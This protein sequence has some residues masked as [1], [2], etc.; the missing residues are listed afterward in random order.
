MIQVVL[1]RPG[2]TAY[3]EQSRV[4]GILDLPLSDRGRQEVQAL[5]EHLDTVELTAIY[6]GPG[7]NVQSTADALGK[8]MG[9]R[10]RRLEEL[11]NIDQGLWQ[12]L[13]VDEIKRRS[14]KVYRLW[15]EEPRTICPPQGEAVDDAQDRV[16]QALKPILKRH[17]DDRIAIVVA[18]P[19]ARLVAGFLRRE[20]NP[21]FLEE[22][23]TGCFEVIEV[24]P[25]VWKNGD[26]HGH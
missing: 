14:P 23:P 4:Q 9:L 24:P 25:D 19:L 5:A 17:R 2:A 6:N 26:S 16:R 11:R 1:I 12:G 13:Q 10:P 3:D 18:D 7:A 15:I 8:V 21:T 20:A 22:P